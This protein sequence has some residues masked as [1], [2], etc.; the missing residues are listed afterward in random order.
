MIRPPWGAA[1]AS[2]SYHCS[3][4]MAPFSLIW[5]C[6][7]SWLAASERTTQ[8]WCVSVWIPAH[9]VVCS[10][11]FNIKVPVSIPRHPIYRIT[12]GVL[13]NCKKV[14]RQ[15]AMCWGKNGQC[16][17]T[18]RAVSTPPLLSVQTKL[19]VLAGGTGFMICRYLLSKHYS[20]P[21][22][23]RTISVAIY[24]IS[25]PHF[26]VNSTWH[27]LERQENTHHW[28]FI[29]QWNNWSWKMVRYDSSK[30]KHDHG[31]IE[32]LYSIVGLHE[33]SSFVWR[34]MRIAIHHSSNR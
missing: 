10:N 14:L 2:Y 17:Y 33:P 27:Y 34:P 20:L 4:Q 5:V 29:C 18:L 11:L 8:A 15:R 25:S 19:R 31:I 12:H 6:V 32:M 1:I 9:I 30:K 26:S 7:L 22:Q 28:L 23:C 13:T 21:R 24:L 16:L 3:R